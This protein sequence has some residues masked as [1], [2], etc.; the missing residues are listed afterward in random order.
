MSTGTHGSRIFYAVAGSAVTPLMS[1]ATAPILAQALGVEGRGDL[2][3]GM[4]PMLFAVAVGGLGI[5]EALTFHVARQARGARR[6]VRRAF[7]LLTVLGILSAGAVAWSAPLLAGDNPDIRQLMYVTAVLCVPTYWASIPAS[8]LAGTH[9]WKLSAVVD[10][11]V[12]VV[13]LLLLAALAWTDALIPLSATVV[14]LGVP[15]IKGVATF[16]Y[17]LKYRR[18]HGSATAKRV[19]LLSYGSRLWI[20]SLAGVMLLRLDQLLMVPLAGAVQLGLYAVAVS[21]GEVP[22]VL[23]GAVRNVV[24]SADAA[25]A[26]DGGATDRLQQTARLTSA[27]AVG[28]G[29]AIGSVLPWAVPLFF[30]PQFEQAVAVAWVVL[31]GVVLGTSG[32]VAGAGLSARG[33]PGLRSWGMV[34]GALFNTAVLL[35][36]VPALGALG[37]ALATVAGSVIAGTMNIVWLRLKFGIR[38]AGFYGLRRSDLQLV[39]KKLVRTTRKKNVHAVSI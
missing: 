28:A 18:G 32:S 9:A 20:G 13:R 34:I 26:D 7:A 8:V 21:V 2:A 36:A 12:A 16:P 29:L 22:A 30:G 24:F 14:M 4:A 1:L 31:A 15:L 39:L 19:R 5:P 37:A 33:R 6:S 23:A 25:E 11:A 38:V 17:L 10:F 27:A 3:A 35:A